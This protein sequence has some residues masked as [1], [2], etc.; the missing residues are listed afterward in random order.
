MKTEQI[1]MMIASI[2][3]EGSGVVY[4]DEGSGS[5]GPGFADAETLQDMLDIGAFDDAI[6]VDMD[7]SLAI[8]SF[9]NQCEFDK[10]TDWTQI[11][12]SYDDNGYN[13]IAWIWSA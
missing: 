3:H 5:G 8:D 10:D 6:A 7:E 9:A 1:K 2:I 11:E 13:Q 12:Y 4:T